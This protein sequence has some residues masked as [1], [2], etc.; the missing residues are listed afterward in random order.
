MAE[1]GEPV[2][3]FIVIPAVP[4]EPQKIP[5]PERKEPVKTPERVPA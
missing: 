3:R 5:A 1:I 2:R 4:E